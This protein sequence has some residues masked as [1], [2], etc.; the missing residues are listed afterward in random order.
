[1]GAPAEL[2]WLVHEVHCLQLALPSPLDLRDVQAAVHLL[3]AEQYDT[4]AG[5]AATPV[6]ID[7]TRIGID[8]QRVS[9]LARIGYP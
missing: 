8:G 6:G 1:M 2:L 3:P 7:A 4:T 5:N 9:D